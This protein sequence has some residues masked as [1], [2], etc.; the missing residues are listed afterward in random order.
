MSPEDYDCSPFSALPHYRYVA[1]SQ[2]NILVLILRVFASFM[3]AYGL[4]DRALD[5]VSKGLGID[6]LYATPNPFLL[7]KICLNQ[8][9]W[10]LIPA[11]G[12]VM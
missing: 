8:K 3:G 1:L 5:S 2:W 6:A 9:V 4:V 7:K 11:T 12:N 10:A